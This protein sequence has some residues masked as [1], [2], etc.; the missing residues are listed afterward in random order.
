MFTEAKWLIQGH[1][2]GELQNNQKSF[3]L[4]SVSFLETFTKKNHLNFLLSL[5]LRR[6]HVLIYLFNQNYLSIFYYMTIWASL[7]AQLVKNL[8]AGQETWV[9]F[10]GGEDLLEKG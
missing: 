1:S 3:S 9:W 5:Y 8:P 4:L 10:L 7:V 6:L 2:I